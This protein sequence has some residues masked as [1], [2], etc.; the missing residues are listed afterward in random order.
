MRPGQVIGIHLHLNCRVDVMPVATTHGQCHR[1]AALP[2]PVEYA[3]V[4]LGHAFGGEFQAPQAVSFIHIGAC[5]I[6][7]QPR[8]KALIQLGQRSIQCAEVGVV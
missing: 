5:Q 2:A 8:R 3:A 1:N 4:A 7:D 6:D